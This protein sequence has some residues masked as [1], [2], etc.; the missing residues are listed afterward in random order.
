MSLL[1]WIYIDSA[2]LSWTVEMSHMAS[3]SLPSAATTGLV[4]V[5]AIFP[6][7]SAVALYLRVVAVRQKASTGSRSDEIW[8]LVSWLTTAPLS[9]VVWVVAARSGINYYKI[10]NETGVKYSLAVCIV[11]RRNKTTTQLPTWFFLFSLV[12]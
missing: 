2:L 1:S 4:V 9:I 3:S 10:N 6:A 12:D 11:P 8:L 5:S 7:L